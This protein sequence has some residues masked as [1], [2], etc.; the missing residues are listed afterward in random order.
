VD[1]AGH[2]DYYIGVGQGA[3]TAWEG[4]MTTINAD[5]TFELTYTDGAIFADGRRIGAVS[6]VDGTASRDEWAS[7]EVLAWLDSD[8]DPAT[9]TADVVTFLRSVQ[10]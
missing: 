2:V 3:R 10:G 5:T 8:S 9:L 1:A 4:N 6:R 7:D